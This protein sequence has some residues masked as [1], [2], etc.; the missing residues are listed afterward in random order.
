M[1]KVRADCDIL[2]ISLHWGVEESFDILKEQRQYAYDLLDAGADLI[3]GHHPH[4]FQGIEMYKGKPIVYSL[5]NFIFDQND[6]E[7]QEAFILD[8]TY[9]NKVLTGFTAMPVRTIA[10]TQVVPVYGKDAEALLNR[11][12]GLCK[13]LGTDCRIENDKL[14]FK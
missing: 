6:P 5:G 8:M 2:I 14:I 12:A 9:Q 1:N 11:E 4:Q 10:K 3:L 7:N 13:E